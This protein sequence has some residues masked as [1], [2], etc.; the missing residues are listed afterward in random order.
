MSAH[1]CCKALLAVAALVLVGCS[2]TPRQ[3]EA[4]PGDAVRDMVAG[5]AHDPAAP[6]DRV[7]GSDGQAAARAIDAYRAPEAPAPKSPLPSILVP[8]TP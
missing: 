8:A 3:P 7:T 1:D 4:R 2:S 6:H 5:Q